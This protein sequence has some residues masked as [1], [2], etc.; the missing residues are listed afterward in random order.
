MTSD[1]LDVREYE[2]LVQR[3]D[4]GAVVSFAG[5]VRDED[6]GRGVSFL[7]YEAHPA[8]SE[9]IAGIAATAAARD[10]VLRVAVAHRY[11]RVD[12]TEAALVCAVSA[13]HRAEA[14]ETCQWI[15]D[16]VKKLLP[17]WKRQVFPDGTDE[18]VNCP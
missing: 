14:F 15:V 5:V 4:A 16:E 7:E 8:A 12:I 11:G 3:R 18:W 10:G 13:P 9:V 1:R 17:V 2:E 6:H